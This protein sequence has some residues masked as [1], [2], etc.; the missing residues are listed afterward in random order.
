[1]YSLEK[2]GKIWKICR[3]FWA[4][5]AGLGKF[6]MGGYGQIGVQRVNTDTKQLS[7]NGPTNYDEK[8]G[9]DNS[10]LTKITDLREGIK[11]AAD[12]CGCQLANV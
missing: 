10:I 11:D 6:S 7:F 5:M 3:F 12:E 4:A 1:M 9:I 8:K 2:C